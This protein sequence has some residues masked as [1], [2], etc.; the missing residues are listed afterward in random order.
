VGLPD[1]LAPEVYPLA[2]LV[3]KWRGDGT[4]GYGPI[5]PGRIVQELEFHAADGPYLAYTARTWLVD[6]AADQVSEVSGTNDS[7]HVGVGPSDPGGANEPSGISDPSGIRDSSG[8][9]EPGGHIGPGVPIGP[10]GV[11]DPGGARDPADH[12]YPGGASDPADRGDPGD[13]GTGGPSGTSGPGHTGGPGDTSTGYGPP[14]PRRTESKPGR[15]WHQEAGFWRVTPGQTQADPPFEIE[16]LISDAAGYQSVYLGQVDG[17]RIDLATDA[18]I[19]TASAAEINAATRLYG[20]VG[21]DLM[22]AWD[23]AGFGQPLGSYLAA[24]LR[25]Q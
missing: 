13:T 19:R 11:G 6:D 17:P 25:R 23:I 9:S 3:G 4:I 12:G 5:K 15:L 7:G 21:G 22:W 16:V 14:E 10:G 8:I 1:D 18:V 2:W 24:Q 20:L